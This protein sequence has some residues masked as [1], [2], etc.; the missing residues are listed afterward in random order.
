ML[1]VL[2]SQG[3]K[4]TIYGLMILSITVVFVVQFRPG[5]GGQKGGVLK[6]DCA[7]EVRGECLSSRDFRTTFGLV[8]RRDDD[9]R[10]KRMQIKKRIVDGLVEREL[11]AQDA[12]R[13]GVAVSDDDLNAAL[14]A[15]QVLVS[16]PAELPDFVLYYNLG[17]SPERPMRVLPVK[18]PDGQFDK[19]EYE[20]ALRRYINRGAAEFREMQQQEHLAARVRDLVRSRVRVGDDEAYGEFV[21][22]KAKATA[23]YVRFDRA[24]FAEHALDES[25]AAVDAWAAEHK[26]EVDKAWE[27]R[28]G[29][30][31]AECRLARAVAASWG[32]GASDDEKAALRKQVDEARAKAAKGG[33]V[34][35]LARALN[36]D[37]AIDPSGNLGCAQPARLPKPMAE[38]L[39]ALKD[40]EVS[41]VGETDK[42]FFFLKLEAALTGDKAEAQGRREAARERRRATEAEAKAS[43]AARKT[44]EAAAAGKP[45]AEALAEALAP[46]A[47]AEAGAKPKADPKGDKGKGE[48]GKGGKGEAAAAPDRAEAPKVEEAKDFGR[49]GAPIRGLP[50]GV[51]LP[52]AV[53]ALDK[54]GDL[55]DLVRLDSGYLVAQ[56]V[57]KTVPSRADFDADKERESYRAQLLAAKRHDAL[58]AYVARLRDAAKGEIKVNDAYTKESAPAPGESGDEE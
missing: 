30:G 51:D 47:R 58:A 20:K 46:Y 14:T 9:A 38:A 19:K 50:F 29:Q 6:T 1:D 48:A 11:L 10:L 37:P 7:A 44:R 2:R 57:G 28:K 39:A 24:W 45:L 8:A 16:M 52:S 40:G 21:R 54:P 13:L 36:N 17:L 15:G 55:T 5:G 34:A 18:G 53:F 25:D 56:L 3:L 22:R 35:A 41:P 49:E 26:D 4:N 12:A 32:E 31:A 42:G 27:A 23:K 43:E 33:D